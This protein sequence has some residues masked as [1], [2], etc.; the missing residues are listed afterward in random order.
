[1]LDYF[2][3]EDLQTSATDDMSNSM[4]VIVPNMNP[5]ETTQ[6]IRDKH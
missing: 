2:D 6:W 3:R 1:M 5:I 4:R